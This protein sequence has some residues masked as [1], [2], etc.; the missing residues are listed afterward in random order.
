ML[1]GLKTS[2]SRNS[3][4]SHENIGNSSTHELEEHPHIT[5]DDIDECTTSTFSYKDYKKLKAMKCI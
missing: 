3:G 4:V 2:I 1:D 5:N